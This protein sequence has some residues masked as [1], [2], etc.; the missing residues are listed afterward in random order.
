M[1]LEYWKIDVLVATMPMCLCS[2]CF[3]TSLGSIAASLGI[4][5]C[6]GT[7]AGLGY[8]EVGWN[9]PGHSAIVQQGG[10][11][12]FFMFFYSSLLHLPPLRFE[13]ML[14]SNPGLLRLQML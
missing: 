1:D 7:T 3:R 6:Y 4:Q 11:Y 8:L 14:G 5:R 10:F 13:R 9:C 12:N 2:S